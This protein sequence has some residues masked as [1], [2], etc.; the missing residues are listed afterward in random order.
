[1]NFNLIGRAISKYSSKGAAL[2]RKELGLSLDDF[3]KEGFNVKLPSGAVKFDAVRVGQKGDAAKHFTD[4]FTFR[5]SAGEMVGRFTRKTF[6]KNVITD[7][8]TISSMGYS[9]VDIANEIIA[10]TGKRIKGYTRTNGKITKC[11]DETVVLTDT[12][13]P[14]LTTFKRTI[15]SDTEKIAL[16]EHQNGKA[17]KFFE[18]EYEAI[19][20]YDMFYDD[21]FITHYVLKDSK[22]SSEQLAQIVKDRNL[23]PLVSPKNKFVRR[24]APVIFDEKNLVID[25][26]VFVYKKLSNNAGFF[27]E[28]D[29]YVNLIDIKGINRTRDALVETIGHE[30]GHS[31]WYDLASSYEMVKAGVGTFEEFGITPDRLEHI[32]KYAHSIK[33]YISSKE[34]LSAYYKQFCERMARAEGYKSRQNYKKVEEAIDNEFKYKHFEQF[35][36]TKDEGLEG[37]DIKDIFSDLDNL[38]SIK[39]L[40]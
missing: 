10:Q 25:P 20:N 19:K 18:N 31:L 16:Y 22:A 34:N 14:Y 24:M 4:I 13:K 6:G 2:V 30:S 36:P 40:L 38:K 8:K 29:I 7:Y 33:N 27:D 11:W 9:D 15:T 28:R 39:D 32:K 23:L 17:A 35:Y 26:R 1:M 12:P 3:V 37:L 5:D 21:Y